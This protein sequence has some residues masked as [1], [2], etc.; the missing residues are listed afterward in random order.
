MNSPSPDAQVASE[1]QGSSKGQMP[2][3]LNRPVRVT[4]VDVP[5][6]QRFHIRMTTLYAGVVFFVLAAMGVAFHEVA[7]DHQV[8]ALQSRIRTAAT[9]LSHEIRAEAV[10]ALN[11]AEDSAKPE[12]HELTSLFAR[13]GADEPEFVSIYVMRPTSDPGMLRF[14]ADWVAEGRTEAATVGELYDASQA[15]RL[16]DGFAHPTVEDE[17]TTDRWGTVLSG[18]A[19]IRGADGRSVGLVGVDVTEEEVASLKSAVR[20]VTFSVF[21]LATLC[22]ALASWFV[23][24]SVRGPL[25]HITTATT[26][27]AAG[28][29]DT[30]VS[31]D[32][33]DEFGLLGKHLDRMASDLEDRDYV[34]STFGRYVSEDVARELLSSRKG[35]E[36]GGA[37][38]LVTVLASDLVSYSTISERLSPN[39]TVLLLNTYFGLMMDVIDRH[40]GCVI[41]FVGDG[42]LCVFGTPKASANHAEL[43]VRCA[44]AMQE[45]LV[46]ANREWA[47]AKEKQWF[48]QGETP[49][50]MRIGIHT[51]PVIVGNIGAK[52]RLKYAVI[53]DTVNVAARVEALNKQLGTETLIT[54]DTLI[55]LPGDLRA[56]TTSQGD[57]EIRGRVR[58]VTLHSV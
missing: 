13:V 22:L 51:G 38:R 3:P 16:L 48:G 27:I 36:L 18:Y 2:H 12:Y 37:E 29:L 31:M 4:F 21:G 41:D 24:T 33:R 53:G 58:S 45:E 35:A 8:K 46:R 32:R 30:R 19:P 9:T 23:G 39:D 11:V 50:K 10:L 40:D 47:E 14:A 52:S 49:I 43:A 17:F 54:D 1:P 15:A 5:F 56:R 20:M 25:G 34:R 55:R 6:W 26:E 28:H 44:I 7:V 57:H 42:I